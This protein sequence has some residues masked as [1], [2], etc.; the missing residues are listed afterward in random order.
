MAR[1][2]GNAAGIANMASYPVL[3]DS[4]SGENGSYD[5]YSASDSSYYDYGNNDFTRGGNGG[6]S[7]DDYGNNNFS[8]SGGDSP[9]ENYGG[10]NDDYG[11]RNN[12]DY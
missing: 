7:Y 4:T 1:N 6:A 11:G 9:Y 3:S 8:R 10:N 2:R 12:Y 5:E